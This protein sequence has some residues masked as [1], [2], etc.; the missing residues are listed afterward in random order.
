[1]STNIFTRK[2]RARRREIIAELSRLSKNS[3]RDAK[4]A[5][6]QPLERELAALNAKRAKRN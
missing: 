1:M 3:W 5:D 2:E 4:P 6:Y